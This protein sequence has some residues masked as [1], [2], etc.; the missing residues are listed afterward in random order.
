MRVVTLWLLVHTASHTLATS[1]HH[2]KPWVHPRLTAGGRHHQ[3]SDMPTLPPNTQKR[4]IH[5]HTHT[6]AYAHARACTYTPPLTCEHTRSHRLTSPFLALTPGRAAL[7]NVA[8]CQL[9]VEV[10]LSL[11]RYF[12]ILLFFFKSKA[13]SI[14][15]KT[16]QSTIT[17]NL[18]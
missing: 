11:L 1:H 8:R 7:E 13:V 17:G 5:A 9:K 18:S 14:L 12:Q 4:R 15:G 16:G 6:C 3:W 2:G 10:P